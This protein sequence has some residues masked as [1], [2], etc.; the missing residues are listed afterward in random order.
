MA[1]PE[2]FQMKVR[3]SKIHDNSAKLLPL[4]FRFP[5][6]LT[7]APFVAVSQ[8]AEE[9]K[10]PSRGD[11]TTKSTGS[12][13]NML[14]AST[15]FCSR[16]SISVFLFFA[17]P[18]PGQGLYASGYAAR[19]Y[20]APA[21]RLSVLSIMSHEVN[22][23]FFSFSPPALGSPMSDREEGK[24]EIQLDLSGFQ[25]DF[26]AEKTAN[27]GQLAPEQLFGFAE[28]REEIVDEKDTEEERDDE[29]EEK[30]Q[31]KEEAKG[32][33]SSFS[34]NFGAGEDD[35]EK[36]DE[37]EEDGANNFSF[38]FSLSDV[39][40]QPDRISALRPDTRSWAGS[41]DLEGIHPRNADWGQGIAVEFQPAWQVE[42]LTLGQQE[43]EERDSEEEVDEE[44]DAPWSVRR[45]RY[46]LS[47]DRRR[48]KN[49][50]S[51]SSDDE[52]E[53]EIA[54]SSS[55]CVSNSP[56]PSLGFCKFIN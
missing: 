35:G 7:P 40:A 56:V 20:T 31:E 4:R 6:N 28:R 43:K 2:T 11:S 5:R 42:Q 10:T 1:A 37:Q 9:M 19:L 32:E 47:R 51:H 3:A 46:M 27:G 8:I 48:A 22:F 53:E 15:C 41:S 29:H 34:F 49:A 50:P 26:G 36:D 55:K 12:K 25:F 24:D 33:A 54:W 23:A 17:S 39:A 13:S 30:Q 44:P 16:S 45:D 38:R 18:L 52:H 21:V 14:E